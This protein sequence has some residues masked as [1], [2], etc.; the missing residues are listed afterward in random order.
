MM[1]PRRRHFL[2]WLCP[3]ILVAPFSR[4]TTSTCSTGTT[5][6]ALHIGLRRQRGRIPISSWF[7]SWTCSHYQPPKHI[8]VVPPLLASTRRWMATTDNNDE[9]GQPQQEDNFVHYQSSVSKGNC[10]S[11]SEEEHL[12]HQQ[13][14][15]DT[16]SE[17]FADREKEVTP[18]LEPIYQDMANDILQ[19]IRDASSNSSSLR[20]LD[21]ACGTGVLWEFLFEAANQANLSLAIQGVD[22]SPAMVE[23]ASKRAKR[24]L[25]HHHHHN[26]QQR[27]RNKKDDT[28]PPLPTH[29]I[30]VLASDI[31]E[32]CHSLKPS[33]T[34]AGPCKVCMA[35][36]MPWTMGTLPRELSWSEDWSTFKNWMYC[37]TTS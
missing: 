4:F 27:N 21:V 14:V 18:D 25:D 35:R 24:L 15:F 7:W 22:L 11:T 36:I 30:D 34:Y 1:D 31:I 3:M 37:D 32:Y 20:L 9:G 8:P 23:H 6:N 13:N 19:Q 12:S 10:I 33:L 17:W 28:P 2:L 26:T 5:V 29:T 16:M